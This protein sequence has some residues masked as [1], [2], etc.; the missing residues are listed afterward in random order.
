[1]KMELWQIGKT[2]FPFLEAGIA[3]YEKRLKR[4][5]PFELITIPDIRKGGKLP[6]EQLMEKEGQAVLARLDTS[7][8]LILLDEQG[9]QYRSID[10]AQYLEALQHQSHRK[11]VLLIGGAYGFSGEVRHRANHLI[12]LSKMT[13]SHQMVRLFILE[14]LYRAQTILRN[15]PYHHE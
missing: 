6:M 12:S 10:F 11:V 2:A 9:K 15:E 1:M 13:F 3:E 5:I 14:Q 8:Y 4:Y 7:D